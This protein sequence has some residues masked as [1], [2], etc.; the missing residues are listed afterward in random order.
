MLKVIIADDDESSRLVLKETLR[1]VSG[2]SIVGEAENGEELIRIVEKNDVDVVFLDINM[3]GMTGLEAASQISDINPQ[4]FIIFATGYSNYAKEAF[5]VYAFDYIIKPFNSERIN[6]TLD[7][8]KLRLNS[9]DKL[10]A[11]KQAVLNEPLS[12]CK[13]NSKLLL[14]IDDSLIFIKTSDIIFITRSDRKTNIHTLNGIFKSN[15]SLEKIDNR[16]GKAFFR[17]HKGYI[18]NP[19]RVI[20]IAPWG[21][22]TYIV[23]FDT[24]NETAL[25]THEKLKL[26]KQ[27]FS[28]E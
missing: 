17:S 15:E 16:L 4:I 3:P 26:F 27:T 21:R 7:R 18:I 22:K 1:R 2:I 13:S 25:M 19:D 24:G 28:N 23:R 5:D 9:I 6:K 11:V 14:Q 20:E 8:I 10:S 12:Y